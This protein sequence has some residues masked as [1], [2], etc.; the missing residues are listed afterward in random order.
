MYYG[1]VDCAFELF[2]TFMEAPKVF[3]YT[4]VINLTLAILCK[5]Y[6]Y[7]YFGGIQAIL[8]LQH[9]NLLSVGLLKK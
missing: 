6:I 1:A 5:W 9:F 7:L 3:R 8:N 2:Y 4:A